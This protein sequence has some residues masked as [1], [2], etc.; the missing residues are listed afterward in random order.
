MRTPEKVSTELK[1]LEDLRAF[2]PR[3]IAVQLAVLCLNLSGRLP[4]DEQLNLAQQIRRSAISIASNIAE[5]YA[6]R[7]AR[8]YAHYLMVAHGSLL[9]LDTQLDIAL[10][11]RYLDSEDLTDVRPLV[12]RTAGL[13]SEIVRG[14]GPDLAGLE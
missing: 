5:G 14:L 11:A 10:G 1:R 2:E 9:E 3:R 13:L 4:S 12:T 8:G 6:R 7:S